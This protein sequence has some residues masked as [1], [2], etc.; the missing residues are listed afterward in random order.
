MRRLIVAAGDDWDPAYTRDGKN[1][2]W[3]SNRSGNYEVWS[4]ESDGGRA[5]RLTDD[6]VDA[7]NP[8][9]TP[10]GAWIVYAS[11]N[12]AKSG[13]WKVRPDGKEAQ[14]VVAGTL[15]VPELSPD[16]LW[17]ACI[18]TGNNLLRVVA[19]SDGAEVA[20]IALPPAVPLGLLALGR[21]R[22]LPGSST[23]AWLD[24]DPASAATR[25]VAQEIVP[26]RD[27]SSS[28][29]TLLQGTPDSM[30]ESFAVSPDGSRLLVSF[31]QSRSD[32]LL[33]E[34]LRGVAR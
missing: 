18:D 25:L 1:V 3:S 20:T 8:T 13:V 19:L 11:A 14:L 34:G 16:G 4:A 27:T 2:L 15:G 33:V 12:P 32:L 22:W 17:I 21:S 26:G 23:L 6:G 24:Y 28:R 5:R 30:P 31:D 29:R 7:E 9:S 10:N